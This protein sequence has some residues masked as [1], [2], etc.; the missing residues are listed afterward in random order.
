MNKLILVLIHLFFVHSLHLLYFL[1]TQFNTRIVLL[2][3]FSNS[4]YSS[5]LCQIISSA[6]SM[7]NDNALRYGTQI[8]SDL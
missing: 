4:I 7:I 2:E 8:F 6:L 5:F 3:Q 1:S